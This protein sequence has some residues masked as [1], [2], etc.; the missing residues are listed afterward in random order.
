MCRTC[1]KNTI[2]TV[3]FFFSLIVNYSHVPECSIVLNQ[4]NRY[5]FP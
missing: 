1:G 2:V 3:A 4:A 5:Y